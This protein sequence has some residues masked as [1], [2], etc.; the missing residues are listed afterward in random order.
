[1]NY[2]SYKCLNCNHK[3]TFTD[4]ELELFTT[5][6]TKDER[7]VMHNVNVP[8]SECGEIMVIDMKGVK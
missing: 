4:E 1:M 3:Q 8:C 6:D 7:I 2:N 5:I